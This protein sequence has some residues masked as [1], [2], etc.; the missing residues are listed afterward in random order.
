MHHYKLD[1]IKQTVFHGKYPRVF[2]M[3]H[4]ANHECSTC[5]HIVAFV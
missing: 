4:F 1:P 3:A 2:F 5:V